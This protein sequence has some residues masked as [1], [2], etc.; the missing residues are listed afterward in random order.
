MAKYPRR[1]K[2]SKGEMDVARTVWRLKSATVGQIHDSMPNDLKMDYSTVQTYIRRLEEKGYLKSKRDGRTKIYSAR[3]RP[4]TV[5][6]E[7]VSDLMDQLFDGQM[8][9]LV[10]QLVDDRGL[11]EDEIEQLRKLLDRA[12]QENIDDE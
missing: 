2:L 4:G 8:F 1:P 5:I 10:K 7:V 11:S 9:P 12:E 6:G 3:I